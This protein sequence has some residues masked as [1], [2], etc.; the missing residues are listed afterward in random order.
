MSDTNT[1]DPI[2]RALS[3]YVDGEL[4]EGR[5]AEV[6]E[7]LAGCDACAAELEAIEDV[8]AAARDS[9]PM[10][11][12]DNQDLLLFV[13]DRVQNQVVANDE[14]ANF[15]GNESAFLRSR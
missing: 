3:A 11:E 7:H 12:A 9:V 2:R 15:V 14:L 6:A 13:V 5:Q 8:A 4:D 10:P 1:C